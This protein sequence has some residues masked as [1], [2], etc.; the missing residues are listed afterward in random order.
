MLIA[1]NIIAIAGLSLILAATAGAQDP[2]P[3]PPDTLQPAPPVEGLTPPPAVLDTGWVPPEATDT[4]VLVPVK[5]AGK[6]GERRS[7]APGVISSATRTE[8]P[9]RDIP[10]SVTV[11]NRSVIADLSMQGMADVARYIP[12]VTMGQG[13]GHR[14]QPTI[15]GNSTTADFFI[16]GVRDDAQY[17]RDLYNV[18]RVEA[19]KGSNAMMFGRGGGGGV[20]NRAI[21]EADWVPLRELVLQGGS[22]NNRRTTLDAGQGVTERLA[23]RLNAMYENSDLFRDAVAVERHGIHPTV[24]FLSPS[25]RTKA[26]LGYENFK[27]H[28]TVDRGIPSFQGRPLETDLTTFFGN[29][30]IS[31][32][33]A[34]V[35]SSAAMLAHRVA[36]LGIRNT[37]RFTSYTKFYQNVFSG[38]VS[39]DRSEVTLNGYN[40]AHD[41]KNLIS[42]TD[43]S[44]VV[45][46][47]IVSH[48]LLV[49]AELG[50]QVT[51]NFRNTGY[52]ADGSTAARVP[53]SSPTAFLPVTFRQS[54]SDA[55]NHVTNSLRSIYAQDQIAISDRLQILGGIR[56]ESF[57]IR[58]HNNRN[59]STLRRTDGMFSPRIG[60]VL[61]P[62]TPAS[63]YAS[64]SVSHLPSAGDQFSSLSDVTKALEP[65]SF[66]NL[67]I[68]AKWDVGDRLAFTTAAYRLDRTNTTAPSTVDPSLIVQT[69]SQR[70][71]GYE[72]GLSGSVS[73]IWDI[74]G[75]FARQKAVITSTTTS[76]VRGTTVPLVPATTFSLWSKHQLLSALGAGVGVVHQTPMYAAIDNAVTL[77]AFT[78]VDAALFATLGSHVR[79]QVNFENLFNEG[80]YPLAHNNNN[81]TPGSPRAVRLSLT[82]GF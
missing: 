34:K 46:T 75:G 48:A 15:R 1:P 57:S 41:R 65:E 82:T 14:D 3:A 72:L 17:F 70:S 73:P 16:D 64:Y 45:R 52:F 38:P 22:Y 44:A 77:P 20:I 74:V 78:R 10:Q 27:D 69:G 50:R 67:E 11:I 55:D 58:Y 61:K 53:T 21:K 12:G 76:A 5:V 32:A 24:T 4:Q 42:Q 43:L 54:A 6:R 31:Y 39:A 66:E 81:I 18:E 19:L 51:D 25:G 35:H 60:L 59:A 23:G 36:G 9:L 8:L 40:S 49:G 47:G 30:A 7:Y 80:Y 2:K 37:T 33:D 56:Y 26:T 62:A 29:P 71:T 28:R 13:E 68:G 63:I 79:A